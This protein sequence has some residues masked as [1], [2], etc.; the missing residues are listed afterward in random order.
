M[1]QTRN[2]D[3]APDEEIRKIPTLVDEFVRR[4]LYDEQPFF[5]SDEATVWDISTCDADELLMRCS[6]AYSQSVSIDD[7]NQ[8]LWKLLHQLNGTGS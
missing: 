8:P 4:M 1:M 3:F 7:L 5:I 2:V 6:A